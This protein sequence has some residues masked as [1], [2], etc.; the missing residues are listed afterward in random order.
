M[1]ELDDEIVDILEPN[2]QFYRSDPADANRYY[3]GPEVLSGIG[4][5]AVTIVL[6]VML[7]GANEVVKSK[8]QDWLKR[9]KQQALAEKLAKAGSHGDVATKA[10]AV[11]QV[12]EYLSTKGWPAP[13]AAADARE[14]VNLLESR[15]K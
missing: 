15:L 5:A 11:D 4:W 7:T 14:I 8:V 12:T 3:V 6:P 13:M 9:R 1:V 2:L 10:E